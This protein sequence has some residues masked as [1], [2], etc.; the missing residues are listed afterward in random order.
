MAE[1]AVLAVRY[2]I[3]A[4]HGNHHGFL[5]L[6]GRYGSATGQSRTPWAKFLTIPLTWI[7]ARSGSASS[8][9]RRASRV[10]GAGVTVKP[11]RTVGS[12]PGAPVAGAV[13]TA[14]KRV[15]AAAATTTPRRKRRRS[16]DRRW[17][18]VVGNM[19]GSFGSR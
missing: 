6:S 1:R 9:D 11:S 16:A 14:T 12:I 17:E 2:G 19:I 18:V 13:P 7:S 8:A 10:P 3:R 15:A 4:G 5:R